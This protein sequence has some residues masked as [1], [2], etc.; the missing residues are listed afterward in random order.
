[1]KNSFSKFLSVVLSFVMLL[2]MIPGGLAFAEGETT[3]EL[4]NPEVTEGTTEIQVI[5]TN[6]QPKDWICIYS[7]GQKENI[8]T[9][10]HSGWIVAAEGLNKIQPKSMGGEMDDS[11]YSNDPEAWPL[12][13]GEY[14]VVLY[15]DDDYKEIRDQKT[16]VVTAKQETDP[17]PDPEV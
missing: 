8:H 1:M 16:L 12:R 10:N 9:A 3:I 2:G 15:A 4:V 11:R 5:C 6:V 17:T 13:A 14:Q 7:P